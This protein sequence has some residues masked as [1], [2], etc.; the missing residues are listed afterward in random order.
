MNSHERQGISNHWQLECLFNCLFGQAGFISQ[1]A[2]NA[3]SVSISWCHHEWVLPMGQHMV[4]IQYVQRWLHNARN[5]IMDT[6]YL[7]IV[8][9]C[10]DCPVLDSYAGL[11]TWRSHNLHEG[12][13]IEFRKK[14]DE[15]KWLN[16]D[17]VQAKHSMWKH[18]SLHACL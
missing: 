8:V 4:G 16:L 5:Y 10:S 12:H 9:I 15:M 18:C 6:H 14:L 7:C 17:K 11:Y 1:R 13:S 2:S 3:E